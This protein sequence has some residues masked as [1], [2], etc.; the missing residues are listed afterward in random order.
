[1]CQGVIAEMASEIQ[2]NESTRRVLAPGPRTTW[3]NP[4]GAEL[5]YDKLSLGFAAVTPFGIPK[6]AIDSSRRNP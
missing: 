5:F 6:L 3:Q 2:R 4:A 1:M